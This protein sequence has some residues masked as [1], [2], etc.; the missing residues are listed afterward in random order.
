MTRFLHFVV[1]VLGLTAV[2]WIGAHYVASNPLA[3]AI[4]LLIGVV[5]LVGALE[6][7]RYQQA[8]GTLTR[9]LASLSETPTRLED[10]LSQLHPSLRAAARLRIEGERV[11]LPGP[12]LTPYLV[13]LLVLLGMLGTFLG[14]VATLRGTGLA[15][16][17]ATDL[18]AIRA[19]LAAPVQGLGFAFGT[20]VAGVATSAMLGLLSALCRR[21][22]SRAAQALDA[23]IATTLRH[24]SLVHQRE[25]SLRLMQQQ[26]D[27]MPAVLDKL[28][29]LMNAMTQ[30]NQSLNTQ[31]LTSQEVF[32]TKADTAYSNLASSVE[33]SLRD[34]IAEG[35]RAAGTAIQPIVQATMSDLARANL[36]LNDTVAQAVQQQLQGLST[37]VEST[38][39]TV[40]GVWNTALMDHRQ[41]N[42][43]LANDLRGALD[44][45]SATFEQ[46]AADLID[47]VSTRLDS[48]Q[49]SMSQTW[50]KALTNQTQSS[51]QLVRDHRA[52]L[53][54]TVEALAQQ[55]T[56]LLRTVEQSHTELRTQLASHDQGR[57]AAWAETLEAMT[58]SLRQEWEKAG[59][60]TANRQQEI[61]ET[62]SRTALDLSAE[63]KAHANAMI[64]EV[65]RLMQAASEAPRVAAEVVT[66]V[67]QQL[68]DSM[69][70]DNAM[71][72][73]RSRLL[74]TLSVLLDA[75][76]QAST[77]QR[78]AVDAL[79]DTSAGVLNRV[80]TQFT[81]RVQ[82]ETGKLTEVAAQLT[83]SAVEVA[84]LGEAFG[85]AVAL[86]GQSNATLVTHLQGIEAALDKS[87]AR[88]DEQLAYYVA[89]AR[90][91]I[92]LSVMSQRQIM[93]ELQQLNG[94]QADARAQAT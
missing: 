69:A 65:S 45:F 17:N 24:F 63:T 32:H 51:E 23:G 61:C 62:L 55:S 41:M 46:R 88:S 3:L 60:Q 85:Q 54:V 1:F 10:W 16:E 90:E 14:M 48:L 34:G 44:G 13:G 20:S 50:D 25:E 75:V 87:L 35:A 49:D 29:A 59:A 31:L 67:R 8:T 21:E 36:A 56:S 6:L 7:F 72:E 33:Q 76:N 38:A 42:E 28:Q 66:E 79:L 43:S 9:A 30:H 71:L 64:A 73:E 11:G 94:Q 83:G 68:S 40:A 2:G 22:R 12:S 92:D 84:S 78:T 74:E 47:R 37:Q 81:D 15:L 52:S 26:A 27:V 77:E 58:T 82:A 39:T 86:F 93:E 18:Q 53:N 57:L 89:Q 5:Y 80:S 70:R 91:V 19:S 4:T